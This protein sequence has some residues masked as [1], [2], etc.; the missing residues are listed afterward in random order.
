MIQ[1]RVNSVLTENEV[2]QANWKDD[3]YDNDAELLIKYRNTKVID[4]L[5]NVCKKY[6]CSADYIL[7]LSNRYWGN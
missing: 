4:A 1:R 7:G 2:M 5:I 6:N 3:E